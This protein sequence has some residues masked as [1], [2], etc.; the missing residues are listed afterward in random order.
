MCLQRKQQSGGRVEAEVG[1]VTR[2]DTKHTGLQR[3]PAGKLHP[4]ACFVLSVASVDTHL[5][6]LSPTPAFVL[7]LQS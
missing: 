5:V 6:T 1:E 4:T 3:P 2:G 7:Q